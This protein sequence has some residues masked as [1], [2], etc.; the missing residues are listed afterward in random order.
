M[1]DKYYTPEISEF[2][3][4]FEYEYA[5]N[6]NLHGIGWK[7]A[8]IEEDFAT[9]PIVNDIMNH[10]IRVKHLDR[11]DIEGLGFEVASGFYEDGDVQIHYWNNQSLTLLSVYHNGDIRISGGAN[12]EE[13]RF[14]FFHGKIKNKSELKRLMV[15][16][17]IGSND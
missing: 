11:E 17:G 5:F 14:L 8:V 1:T 2:H 9:P 16:L 15:Q 3:V 6:K 4:G 12:N 13:P 7:K 10:D